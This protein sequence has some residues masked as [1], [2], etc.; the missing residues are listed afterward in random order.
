MRVA[1]K[2]VKGLILTLKRRNEQMNQQVN[3]NF[4]PW[5]D[6]NENNVFP[7]GIYRLK[8]SLEDGMS[9]TGKRMFR[10]Q[11]SCMEPAEFVGMSHFEYY[12][13]GTDENPNGINA[14]TMGAR[15]LKALFKAAQIPPSNDPAQLVLSAKDTECLVAL[16][17]YVEKDGA[18]A[19][20]PRN[21]IGGYFRLGER[22][23]GVQGSGG[24]NPPPMAPPPS[25]VVGAGGPAVTTGAPPPPPAPPVAQ[26]TQVAKTPPPAPPAPPAAAATATEQTH[27]CTICNQAV[28]LSQYGAHVQHYS[29]TGACPA[30]A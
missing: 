10:A 13:V 17:E 20:T 6:I 8:I 14:G 1:D 12:V 15:G 4:F 28:P 30:V 24:S 18:Y 22:Q 25:P 3:A 16:N 9:N 21:R 23:V 27:V 29:N 11:F 19:G 26:P 7:T 5:D 2:Y